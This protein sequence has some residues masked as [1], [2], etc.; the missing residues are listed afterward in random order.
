ME[1]IFGNAGTFSHEITHVSLRVEFFNTIRLK[2][3]F[4]RVAAKV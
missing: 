4:I 1:G 3:T 2:P